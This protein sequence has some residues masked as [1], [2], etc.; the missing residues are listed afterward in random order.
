VVFFSSDFVSLFGF[1]FHIADYAL[2]CI[3]FHFGFQLLCACC[4]WG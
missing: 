4:I 1:S 3:Y 2:C